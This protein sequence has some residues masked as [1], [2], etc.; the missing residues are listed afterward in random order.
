[1]AMASTND[2]SPTRLS[3]YPTREAETTTEADSP[4][5]TSS[6]TARDL[7]DCPLSNTDSTQHG[8]LEE[9]TVPTILPDPT[10]LRSYP[11]S[12]T[13]SGTKPP[14][15]EVEATDATYASWH[16]KSEH[17]SPAR[18]QESGSDSQLM[19]LSLVQKSYE[20]RYSPPNSSAVSSTLVSPV[21]ASFDRP[22]RLQSG[23]F[24][25]N[26]DEETYSLDAESDVSESEKEYSGV[27]ISHYSSAD[28]SD[29]E[30][31]KEEEGDCGGSRLRERTPNGST[32]NSE[33]QDNILLGRY[34]IDLP[35][36]RTSDGVDDA[37]DVMN[38]S[39]EYG[40]G[41]V[42]PHIHGVSSVDGEELEK[43]ICSTPKRPDVCIV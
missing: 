35:S 12:H 17:S 33:T 26:D 30:D 23:Y 31:D 9:P 29:N 13:Q 20:P 5:P 6:T 39:G 3:Q 16:I 18:S 1:M 36:D 2:Q 7:E 40:G 11:V 32:H 14:N 4:T 34:Y 15:M 38:P 22:R 41:I 43:I 24:D 25:A 8:N 10:D 42:V 21:M 28:I 27:T 19:D 37:E